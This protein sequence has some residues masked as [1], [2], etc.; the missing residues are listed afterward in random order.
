MGRFNKKGLKDK[1]GNK[2]NPYFEPGNYMVTINRCS[3]IKTRHGGEFCVIECKINQST[4]DE[5]KPGMTAASFINLNNDMTE[6]NIADFL[7]ASLFAL[8]KSNGQ[9]PGVKTW[10]ELEVDGEDYD[11]D[12]GIV[13]EENPLAGLDMEVEAFNVT[14]K[15][16]KPFTVVRFLPPA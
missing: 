3:E 6:D 1:G 8:A 2:R 15:A 14:T 11:G 10:E 5:L 13:S 16:G 12:E 9:D 7:R 4:C